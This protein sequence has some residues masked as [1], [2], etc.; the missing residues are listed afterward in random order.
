MRT[1][2]AA[3]S[4]LAS[5][6]V[7]IG[8][9]QL[10]TAGTT[11]TPLASNATINTAPPAAAPASSTPTPTNFAS[12]LTLGSGSGGTTGPSTTADGTYTGSSVTTRFGAVQVAI[13]VAGGQITDVTAL[14][15]TDKDG[16]SVS[17]SNRAAPILRQEVLAAQ[18]SHVQ[19]ISGATYTSDGYLTSL[20]SAIDQ[21]G[22]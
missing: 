14:H 17:I 18:S 19:A 4:A 6:A 8:G 1:R 13:T 3:A 22:L 11:G 12:P 7:L 2:A 10:G 20:Q 21:A 16:R 15:L 9:W 5:L